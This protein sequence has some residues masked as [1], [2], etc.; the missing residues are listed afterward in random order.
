MN[1]TKYNYPVAPSKPITEDYFGT[2]I[3]D[4][5]RNLENLEDPDVQA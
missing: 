3:T 2:K 4:H 1:Q 5:Y